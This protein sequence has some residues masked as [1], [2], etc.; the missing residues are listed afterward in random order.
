VR[1]Q[2][3]KLARVARLAALGKLHF[4]RA[5]DGDDK[6]E[7][8]DAAAAFGLVIEDESEEE[9]PDDKCYLWPCNVATYGIWIDLQTQWTGG[10][11]GREGLNYAGVISYLK[12]VVQVKRKDMPQV[13]QCIRAME[14]AALKAWAEKRS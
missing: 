8:D 12:E 11:H 13:V 5:T 7:L 10:F 6:A 4:R 3:K 14:R 2:G 9:A 1:C